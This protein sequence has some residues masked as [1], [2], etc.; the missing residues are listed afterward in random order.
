MNMGYGFLKTKDPCICRVLQ[1]ALIGP[2]IK[3]FRASKC[4]VTLGD[5]FSP[6]PLWAPGLSRHRVSFSNIPGAAAGVFRAQSDE[7]AGRGGQT[8]GEIQ[9]LQL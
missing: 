4:P 1:E 5:Y 8:D 9:T 7:C 3:A 2:Q 6:V